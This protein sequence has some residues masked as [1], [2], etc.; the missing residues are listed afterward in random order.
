MSNQLAVGSL[1]AVARQNKTIISNI[2]QLLEQL[3][4]GWVEGGRDNRMLIAG[5]GGSFIRVRPRH[6]GHCYYKPNNDDIAID[7]GSYMLTG[8]IKFEIPS[9]FREFFTTERASDGVWASAT[10][11]KRGFELASIGLLDLKGLE[12]LHPFFG[13]MMRDIDPD[14]AIELHKMA[15]GMEGGAA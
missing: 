1:N 5:D 13:P 11:T 6:Y 2:G 4:V 15:I 14:K 7:S 12:K 8:F 3:C 9:A 10:L